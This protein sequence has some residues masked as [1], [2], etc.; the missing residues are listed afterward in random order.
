MIALLRSTDGN[1][2][3]RYQK[4]IWYLETKQIPFY[5]ICWDRNL[6]MED[7]ESFIYFHKEAKYGEGV[8][9]IFKLGAYNFFL[10]KN[11]LKHRK[12]IKIVHAADLDT[13]IPA[14]IMHVFF[15]KKVIYDIYD[16]YIDSRGIKNKFFKSIITLIEYFN[17]KLSDR[18]IICE[19]EREKQII[20]KPNHLW[21]LPNI[22]NFKNNIPSI[23]QNSKLTIAYVGILGYERGL[24]N[25]IKFA[26]ENPSINFKIAGFG[27]L[28]ILL[29]DVDQYSNIS[30][31]GAVPYT[32]SLEIMAE[33][34]IIYACYETTNPNHILAAPNKYY[35]G[36]YLGKPI[37]TTAGTIVGDKTKKYETGYVIK[38]N[39]EDLDNLINSLKKDDMILKGSNA[40]KL[41]KE[42]YNSYVEDFLENTYQPYI[43]ASQT[44]N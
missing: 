28:E 29:N 3:S 42:K 32:K 8:K 19:P 5:S 21:V 11:L 26:K 40:K 1:P 43:K 17:I 35:E 15:K 14:I 33:A 30:Y 36:L 16:W 6:K 39:Y 37:I 12:K 44:K 20:F 24:E 25:L 4:Y 2:D 34:D 31:Y 41:W 7:S 22:P 13:I 38:E 27:P 9:N 23:T 10:L 18:V